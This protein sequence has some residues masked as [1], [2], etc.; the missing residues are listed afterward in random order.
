MLGPA[1]AGLALGLVL[2]VST[3]ARAGEA[4]PASD[5]PM[6]EARVMTLSRELRCL[7][8]QNQTIADSQADLAVDLRRDI[9]EQMRRG[10]SDDEIK[11]YLVARYGDFV[12]YRPP[13]KASTL[14]LWAAPALLALGGLAL[15]I[16]YLRRRAAQLEAGVADADQ[17]LADEG[18]E[19]DSFEDDSSEDASLEDQGFAGKG[20][21]A[22]GRTGQLPKND[23]PAPNRPHPNAGRSPA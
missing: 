5:D 18:L 11:A 22:T 12:L 3:G 9:R 6:L 8:C 2:F 16:V 10:A 20:L 19:D 1:L 23:A 14:L 4:Q 15:L 17:G 21:G 7:V 13:L